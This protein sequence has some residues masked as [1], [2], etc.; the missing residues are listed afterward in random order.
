VSSG[1]KPYGQVIEWQL[2][3]LATGQAIDVQANVHSPGDAPSTPLLVSLS[4]AYSQPVYVE[5]TPAVKTEEKNSLWSSWIRSSSA[6]I[7]LTAHEFWYR[8]ST[9]IRLGLGK[10]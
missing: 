2:K 3:P 6:Y 5:L 4:S 1:D 8:L 7:S 10:K 9:E